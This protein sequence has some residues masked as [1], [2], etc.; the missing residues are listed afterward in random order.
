M[1]NEL[2]KNFSSFFF[3]DSHLHRREGDRLEQSGQLLD[4]ARDMLV[5][6]RS[7]YQRESRAPYDDS[8]FF[9]DPV[10]LADGHRVDAQAERKRARG[11]KLV[12]SLD[13]ASG[14]LQSYLVDYL[15]VDRDAVI[16]V[17]EDQQGELAL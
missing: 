17:D 1:F 14:K 13:A 9:E 11:G 7:D 16:G 15:P 5:L 4:L 2:A 10:C 12:A 3:G 6:M 8:L